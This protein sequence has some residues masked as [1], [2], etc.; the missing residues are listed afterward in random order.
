[1][2]SGSTLQGYLPKWSPCSATAGVQGP[3]HPF[4]GVPVAVETARLTRPFFS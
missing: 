3:T 2:V 1:M 4:L